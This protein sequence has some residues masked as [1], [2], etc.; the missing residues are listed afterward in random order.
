MKPLFCDLLQVEAIAPFRALDKL[1]KRGI[2]VYDIQKIGPTCLKFCVKSKETEK[3]E[4]YLCFLFAEPI[5]V[6][7]AARGKP[8]AAASRPAGTL[9]AEAAWRPNRFKTAGWRNV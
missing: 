1:V 9:L 3:T 2:S 7:D 8:A 6:R 4:V 5:V